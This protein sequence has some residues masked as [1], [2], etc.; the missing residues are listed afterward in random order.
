MD[1]EQQIVLSNQAAE[2]VFG[3]AGG[4]ILGKTLNALLPSVVRVRVAHVAELPR[5]PQASRPMPVRH[6]IVA[7]RK[8][9]EEFPAEASI[10][11]FQSEDGWMLTVILRDIT[12]NP[13]VV[14]RG[15]QSR[16]IDETAS[17]ELSPESQNQVYPMDLLR[18]RLAQFQT[19]STGRLPVGGAL[20][21]RE[22]NPDSPGTPDV[23]PARN[24]CGNF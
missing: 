19:S 16:P 24:P 3:Y 12:S 20:I 10:S 18:E 9:G 7:R 5:S 8:N 2:R 4:E 11:E 13:Q 1:R 21:V 6:E 17:R 14:P 23:I 15:L 22:N